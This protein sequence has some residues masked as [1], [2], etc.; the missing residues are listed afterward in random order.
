MQNF[1][2]KQKCVLTGAQIRMGSSNTVCVGVCVCGCVC[3]CV[4]VCVGVCGCV[5]CFNVFFSALSES[6]SSLDINSLPLF[7][8]AILSFHMNPLLDCCRR[9]GHSVLL[10]STPLPLSLICLSASYLI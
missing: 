5:S 8:A 1:V 2:S 3:V 4:C 6:N 7:N 10:L 9:G